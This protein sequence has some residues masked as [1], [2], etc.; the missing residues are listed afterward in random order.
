MHTLQAGDGSD[1]MAAPLAVNTIY[2]AHSWNAGKRIGFG[3]GFFWGFFCF[4]CFCNFGKMLWTVQIHSVAVLCGI[5]EEQTV[6]RM[7]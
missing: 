3:L 5:K 4:F 2:V 6:E 1:S 7:K